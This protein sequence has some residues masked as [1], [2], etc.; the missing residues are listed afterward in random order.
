[1]VYEI[2]NKLFG[3]FNEN[4]KKIEIINSFTR[5]DGRRINNSYI[6]SKNRQ[7]E[8]LIN[9]ANGFVNFERTR[10]RIMYCLNKNDTYL[11]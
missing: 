1:M 7:L 4:S 6:E 9:N 3:L 10:N 11:F 8:H 5:I 2:F